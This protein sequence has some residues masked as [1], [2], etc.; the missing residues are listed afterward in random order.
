MSCVCIG[1]VAS[2]PG[3]AEPELHIGLITAQG[4]FGTPA[5]AGCFSVTPFLEKSAMTTSRMIGAAALLAALITAPA[6]AQEA[7][8][9]PGV[10]AQPHPWANVYNYRYGPAFR[11]GDVGTV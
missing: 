9:Q 11:P 1:G 5:A 7:M 8:R 3:T 6:I 10:Y 2:L 4:G